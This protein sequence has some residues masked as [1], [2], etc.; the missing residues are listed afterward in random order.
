VS[1]DRR[2]SI[3]ATVVGSRVEAD[4]IVGMLASHGIIA[5]VSADDAG[6]VDLALQAQGVRVL[7]DEYDVDSARELLGLAS[8][9]GAGDD[10][11]R[12]QRLVV[13]LLGG[14]ARATS[15]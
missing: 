8:T 15:S 1:E 3:V 13:R 9:S 10:L 7:I 2:R 5:L 6:G 4:M 12:V 14:G 11:N